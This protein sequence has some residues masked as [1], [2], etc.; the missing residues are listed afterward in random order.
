MIFDWIKDPLL[1]FVNVQ[2]KRMLNRTLKKKGYL[3]DKVSIKFLD[4]AVTI[5]VAFAAGIKEFPLEIGNGWAIVE[6]QGKKHAYLYHRKAKSSKDLLFAD[7]LTTLKQF[8]L[9]LPTYGGAVYD[10]L[11]DRSSGK[12]RVV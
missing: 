2:T 10:A 4:D 11:L 3:I 5:D 7:R 8:I 6:F 12:V 9:E 1:T